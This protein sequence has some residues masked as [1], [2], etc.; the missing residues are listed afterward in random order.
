[1]PD[2]H[3]ELRARPG[4]VER[5]CGGGSPVLDDKDVARLDVDDVVPLDDVEPGV[6]LEQLAATAVDQRVPDVFGDVASRPEDPQLSPQSV[7][8]S[9][10]RRRWRLRSVYAVRE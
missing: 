8:A 2:E 6:A 5:R 4:D 1:V 3:V 7:S 10:T 9:Q